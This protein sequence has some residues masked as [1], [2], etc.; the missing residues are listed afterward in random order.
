MLLSLSG[1]SVNRYYKGNNK[2]ASAQSFLLYLD[3]QVSN[4]SYITQIS[5]IGKWCDPRKVD[6]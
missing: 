4:R 6:G 1:M 5:R 2:N 3:Q